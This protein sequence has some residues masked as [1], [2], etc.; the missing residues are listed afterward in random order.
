[1]LADAAWCVVILEA[2][3]QGVKDGMDILTLLWAFNW[4]VRSTSSAV[5][6]DR[7]AKSGKIVTIAA[8]NDGVSGSWDTSSPATGRDVISV[9]SVDKSVFFIFICETFIYSFFMK[10]GLP[11]KTRPFRVLTTL[12]LP[13]PPVYLSR[14]MVPFRYMPHQQTLPLQMMPA[15][16]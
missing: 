1:L 4:L 8:G 16:H 11:S 3:L 7:I 9:G 2:L 10:H 5:V 12:P 13:T 6:A 15:H 14:S